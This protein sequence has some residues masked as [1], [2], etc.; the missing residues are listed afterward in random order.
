LHVT[1]FPRARGERAIE[2][3]GLS[4]PEPV[5]DP[6]ARPDERGG[7]LGRDPFGSAGARHGR[8]VDQARASVQ[9]GGSAGALRSLRPRVTEDPAARAWPKRLRSPAAPLALLVEPRRRS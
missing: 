5:V 7:G 6:I 2:E 8:E 9:P 1:E 4:E 3:V